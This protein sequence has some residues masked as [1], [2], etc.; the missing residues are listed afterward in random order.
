MNF[1]DYLDSRYDIEHVSGGSQVK[2]SGMCPFCHEDRSDLRL[3]VSVEK[4]RGICFHCNQGFNSVK[5][6]MAAEGCGWQRAVKILSD[7]DDDYERFKEETEPDERAIFPPM[8]PLGLDGLAYLAGRGISEEAIKHFRLMFCNANTMIKGRVFYTKNRVII[9][10]HDITG[11]AV[12]WQGRDITGRALR[13]LF[14]PGFEGAGY[15]FNAWSISTNA[16]YLI[17]SEGVFDVFGWWDAGFKNVAATFGKKISEAQMDMIRYLKPKSIFIA[18]DSDAM[19]ENYEFF[20]KFSYLFKIKI[21]DLAG[22][23]A[24]EMTREEK[25]KAL[26]NAKGYDWS[27]KI[28]RAL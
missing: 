27:D 15:L 12:S 17:L 9:P 28:L 20:E 24:D 26:S 18:W 2:V 6:V 10:I 14:P 22:K 1:I 4:G 11:K 5:F 19:W 8:K 3:Y 16:E 7:D 21:V 25:I 23:D 13:Y